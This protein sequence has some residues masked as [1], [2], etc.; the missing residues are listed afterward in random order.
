MKLH[1]LFASI[2]PEVAFLKCVLC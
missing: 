2:N 1:S